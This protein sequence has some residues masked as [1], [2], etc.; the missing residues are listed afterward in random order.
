ML[1]HASAIGDFL[2]CFVIGDFVWSGLRKEIGNLGL[3]GCF[4]FSFSFLFIGFFL[5]WTGYGG[6]CG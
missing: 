4:F 3:L 2:F 6:G 5:L 1:T